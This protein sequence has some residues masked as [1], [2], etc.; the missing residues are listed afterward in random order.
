MVAAKQLPDLGKERGLSPDTLKLFNVRNNA[1]GWE[2]DT[3]TMDGGKATRWKSYSSK[4]PDGVD[5]EKWSKYLWKPSK[6][7]TAKYFYPPDLSLQQSVANADGVLFMVGGEIAMMSMVEAGYRNVTCVF[8]DN[9]IPDTLL[10]DL[11]SWGVS[12]LI[13]VPDRDTAGQK[14]ACNIRDMLSHQLAIDHSALALPYPFEASHGKDVNDYWMASDRNGAKFK[15]SVWNLDKWVLPEP[16]F[17]PVE[18]R[19]FVTGEGVE[20]PV[21]FLQSIEQALDLRG[22]FNSEGWSYK[23]VR[24]PFHDD[25]R[26][27]ANW[28]WKK[29]LLRCHSAC[30][31]SYLAK[32][33]GAQFGIDLRDFLDSTPTIPKSKV[34]PEIAIVPKVAP[35]PPKPTPQPTTPMLRPKLPAFAD[36]TPDQVSMAAKGRKWLDDYLEWTR[37]S[38]ALAPEIFHEAM[39]LWLLATV[40]TRRIKV[41]IGGQ[42]VYP[43]LY[44]L[45]IA[46]T[47]LYRKSTAMGKAKELLKA[48]GLEPLLLPTDVTPEA[49]FDELAGVKPANFESLSPEDRREWLLGRAVAAQRSFMKDECSS[50]FANL[51]KDYN[52]GLTELLLEGYQGDGG[53]L[54]KLLKSKGL[55]SVKDMC[56][57]F[58]GATTPVMYSKYITNE[59]SENGF[60]ARFAIITPEGIPV[61]ETCDEPPPLPHGVVAQLRRVFLDVLPWHGSEKPHA[62]E[63]MSEV[64]TPPVM[65][66]SV[67]PEALEQL[68]EYRKALNYDMLIGNDVEDTKAA[69]YTRLGTMVVKVALLLAVVDTQSGPVRI[70]PQHAYAAQLLCEKWRESLYRLD[71]DVSRAAESG[72]EKVMNYL[73]TTGENGATI[74]DIMRDCAIKQRSY[75]E[76]VL[77]VLHEDGVIEKY[78][79]KPDGAGRPSIRFRIL[80][81]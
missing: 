51:K 18:Q 56:L 60:I 28:N 45:V 8:G 49:L 64:V 31:K 63:L 67:A 23:K 13:L 39:A 33:T 34:K 11:I 44:V 81:K 54:K 2:Y 12:E 46:K 37:Q 14:W 52:A 20:L 29:G 24:C 77:K 61:Y 32:E 68:G 25:A 1:T 59:E 74:R 15:D 57:S 5:P 17:E 53:K 9:N 69:A 66:A 4:C 16:A 27:S 50:I 79:R 70:Q 26:P 72:N 42:E 48:A 10:E 38:C 21:A 47:S 7:E 22:G 43:N 71:R 30:G 62:S 3:R 55:I 36:L 35:E 65:S 40:S 75:L 76:D 6:P 73:R 58:L 19:D 78:E 80:K 41:N